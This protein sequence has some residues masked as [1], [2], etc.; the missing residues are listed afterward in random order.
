V[1]LAQ[2]IDLDRRQ[3]RGL[4]Q[5]VGQGLAAARLGQPRAPGLDRKV[6]SQV[7]LDHRPAFGGDRLA[8]RR[9]QGVDRPALEPV[10]GDHRVAAR[11][12]LAEAQG[13]CS[14]AARRRNGP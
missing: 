7:D 1:G 12:H 8:Q 10:A 11:R 3:M 4:A 2:Q 13:R 5:K 14:S 9:A 6:R